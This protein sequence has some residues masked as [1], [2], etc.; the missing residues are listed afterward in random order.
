MVKML[1]AEQIQQNGN[2][3]LSIAHHKRITLMTYGGLVDL[4]FAD[5]SVIGQ[6]R[7]INEAVANKPNS[8]FGG[9]IPRS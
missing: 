8:L 1:S 6:T 9:S 3:G 5:R 2:I 4:R 7:D